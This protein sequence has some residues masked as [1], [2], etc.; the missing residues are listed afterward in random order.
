MNPTLDAHAQLPVA[1]TLRAAPRI[2]RGSIAPR[3]FPRLNMTF[4]HTNAA[5]RHVGLTGHG[6]FATGPI[7]KGETVAAWG[8]YPVDRATLNKLPSRRRSHSIQIDDDLFMIGPRRPEP[9]EFINHSCEPNTGMLGSVVV[10]AMRDIA[11]GEELTL[12]Y[13]MCDTTDYDEFDC[14]CGA[15][16]CRHRFTGDDWKTPD[17]QARYAGY[18]SAHVARKIAE[19]RPAR[20]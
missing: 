20:A 5:A 7:V 12:D 9:A 1:T 19:L 18:F 14:H 4:L 13:A 8:G 11:A 10:V 2:V 17:V 3:R 16:R 6:V 15:V